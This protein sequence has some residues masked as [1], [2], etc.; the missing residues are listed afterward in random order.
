MNDNPLREE[1]KEAHLSLIKEICG[2]IGQAIEDIEEI[3]DEE[4]IPKI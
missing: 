3:C 4:E 2:K 1:T